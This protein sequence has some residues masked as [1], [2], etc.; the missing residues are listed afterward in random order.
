[1]EGGG[2]AGAAPPSATRDLTSGPI[3][4]TLLLF[5]LPTLGSSILQSLNGS[6]NAIWVGQFLGETALAATTN[7][8]L[9]MFLMFSAVFG[10]GMA[11]A[12]LI[13]Q[14]VGRRDVDGVRRVFGTTMGLFGVASLLIGFVGWMSAPA[15]L[16]LLATPDDVFPMALAYLRVI[17]LGMPPML[18]SVLLTMCLRGIGDAIT[19][20]W[21]IAASVVIDV[22]LNPVFI[23]GLGPAP[24]LGIAGSAVAT[25]V[26]NFVSLV[27]VIYV[28]YARDRMIRL[29][30]PELR[31]LLP[32]RAL[33]RAVFAKGFAIGVQMLVFASSGLALIGLVNR[34]GS[35]MTAAYGAASQLW[36]Y[37]QMPA[38]AVGAAVS[39]MA[40]QNIGADRWDRVRLIARGG[41]MLN[42]AL[43]G[44]LIAIV[45]FI[46]R[47][48]LWLFLGTDGATIAL[49]SHINR[50]VVWSFTLMGISM[51][52]SATV[53]ANGAVIAPL[54]IFGI[55]TLPVRFGVAWGLRPVFGTDGLWVGM[56][57][58]SIAA[59]G[60]MAAF[61]RWGGWRETRMMT[62]PSRIE[63]EEE[64]MACSEPAG[65]IAPVG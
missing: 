16:R 61:Y 7:A 57:V 48:V 32:D 65:K 60:V 18:V 15:L 25:L 12:I 58:G 44:A 64:A 49:A 19:P 24:Q 52:L 59:A 28:I 55:A 21:A 20:L 31:Y 22:A 35:A 63:V 51:V 39:A 10:F 43:T 62:P 3:N 17:F 46:D 50:M 4:S 27:G 34:E 56:W 29:R 36:T 40:A 26:A 14:R 11:A 2:E 37:I 30:G 13:G 38:M 41:I 6:I 53:R 54:I 8:N 47:H 9:V 1:M 23:L 5:A 45:W 33:L 42:L